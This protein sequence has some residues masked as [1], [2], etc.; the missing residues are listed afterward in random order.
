MPTPF[1]YRRLVQFRD[2]DAAGIAH[3]SVFFQ[4]LEEAEHALL[5]SVGLSVAASHGGQFVSWP[6]VAVRCD[7]RSAVRFEE[8]LEIAATIARLGE[9]SITYAFRCECGGRLVAEGEI[10]AVCCEIVH[11]QPPRSIAIPAEY[12][13]KLAAFVATT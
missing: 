4:Y 2:T 12:R 8:T 7:Y 9:K 13:T 11:G 10:T 1:L 6:R 3:F 5:R